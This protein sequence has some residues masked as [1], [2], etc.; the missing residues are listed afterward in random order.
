MR[1]DVADLHLEV[2]DGASPHK[3]ADGHRISFQMGQKAQNV[4]IE[5]LNLHNKW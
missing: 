2:S 3:P 5:L 1:V 4:D